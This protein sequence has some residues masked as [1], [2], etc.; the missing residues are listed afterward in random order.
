VIAA[1]GPQY[2]SAGPAPISPHEKASPL[3]TLDLLRGLA[4]LAVF[5]VHTRGGSFVEFASL[6]PEQKS[7][8][9]AILFG[10]TRLGHEAVLTFFV[11]SGFLVGGQIVER[12][13]NGTFDFF[14][15]TIDRCSRILVPLVPACIFTALVSRYAFGEKVSIGDL[16]G[17][18]VGLNGVLVQNLNHNDPLWSLAFEIW[19]YISGGAVA[20]IITSRTKGACIASLFMFMLCST[21]FSVLPARFLVYWSVGALTSLCVT[22]RHKRG[23]GILGVVMF[24]AGSVSYQLGSA[25][26]SFKSTTYAP[27][28]VSEALICSGLCFLL[29]L[30]CSNSING[31]LMGIRG[32]AVCVSSFSYTLYLTHFPANSMFDLWLPKSPS[33][34]AL[35]LAYFALRCFGC[36]LIAIVLYFA[37]ERNTGAI[38]A[39]L[40]RRLA[41]S[42][43]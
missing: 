7:I 14:T 15:Y 18:M 42:S 1:Q 10:I 17:N 19:F 24:V 39:Y 12:L 38:R 41:P 26:Q 2:L 32:P 28:E 25:T 40:K 16:L 23:L 9:I 27:V 20:Y 30:L 35:S 31:R 36:V 34:T 13:R 22:A 43:A 29:P 37:F 33:I 4:A 5:L 11:L 21:V 8:T 3:T 6:P